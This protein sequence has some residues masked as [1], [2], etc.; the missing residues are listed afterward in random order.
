MGTVAIP[1]SALMESMTDPVAVVVP[2]DIV[3]VTLPQ[4]DNVEL[5]AVVDRADL[6]FQIGKFFLW[7]SPGGPVVL[8]SF[9]TKE[10]GEGFLCLGRVHLVFVPF[11]PTMAKKST[12]FEEE[13]MD[14]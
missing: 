1:G 4:D 14:F 6:E 9:E 5:L 12:G 11:L 3:G 10:D 7:G 8:R 13:D 2:N